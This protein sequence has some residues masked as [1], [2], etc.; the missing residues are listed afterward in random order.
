MS[1]TEQT[2]AEIVAAKKCSPG[3]NA[4]D[5]EQTATARVWGTPYFIRRGAQAGI[6]LEH[7]DAII[8]YT[9]YDTDEQLADFIAA[10]IVDGPVAGNKIM[11]A[12]VIAA[13]EAELA[14]RR[15]PVAD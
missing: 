11:I 1:E 14:S 8:R 3:A 9:A 6:L 2:A 7:L 13:A 15:E 10:M 5:A 4:T 12:A